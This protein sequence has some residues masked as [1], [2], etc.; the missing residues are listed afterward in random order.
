M[1]AQKQ[2]HGHHEIEVFYGIDNNVNAIKKFMDSSKNTYDVC[3]DC[4]GPSYVAKIETLFI[5]EIKKE[6]IGSCKEL[7]KFIELRHLEGIKGIHRINETGYQSNLA[8]QESK[9][10]SIFLTSTSKKAVE[11]QHH[12]FESLWEKAIPA[13]QHINEIETNI[14][15]ERA[16]ENRN[17]ESNK[18]IQLWTNHNQDQYA[19]RLS[20]KSDLIA[21]TSQNTEYTILVEESEYLEELEYDWEYT[22]TQWVNQ[23]KRNP[24]SFLS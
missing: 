1:I 4:K 13:E 14:E 6:N 17:K 2:R 5:T 19:I 24:H 15:Q 16:G 11:L 9:L 20:G 12:V 7:M 3:A 23:N 22:L 18:T 8:V 21:T 10:G